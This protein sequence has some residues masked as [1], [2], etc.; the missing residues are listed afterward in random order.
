MADLNDALQEE[1][2]TQPAAAVPSWETIDE[3]CAVQDSWS[4][5]RIFTTFQDDLHLQSIHR[6]R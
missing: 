5:W 4:R 2:E 3:P 6:S 1:G